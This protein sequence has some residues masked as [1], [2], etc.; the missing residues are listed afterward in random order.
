[1]SFSVST[2]GP[3]GY[4]EFDDGGDT[5]RFVGMDPLDAAYQI[6]Q[7]HPGGVAALARELGVNAGTLQHKLNPNNDRF[8]L[9]LAEAVRLQ[10]IAKTGG[11]LQAWAAAEGYTLSRASTSDGSTDLLEALVFWQTAQA[12]VARAVGDAVTEARQKCRAISRVAQRRIDFALQEAF[13]A[14]AQLAAAVDAS[15]GAQVPSVPGTGL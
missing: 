3:Q 12:A 1:M 15:A 10:R 14:N 6:A 5:R 4:V 8:H 9:T 13:A 11:I 2:G 7:R